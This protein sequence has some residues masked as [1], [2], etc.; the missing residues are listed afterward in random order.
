MVMDI[1]QDTETVTYVI[2]E[3]KITGSVPQILEEIDD[4]MEALQTV[5]QVVVAKAPKLANPAANGWRA[6][7]RRVLRQR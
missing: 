2:P 7:I 6:R 4:M 5:R 3:R 1:E